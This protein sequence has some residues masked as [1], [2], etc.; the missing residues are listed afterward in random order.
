MLMRNV[1]LE[2]HLSELKIGPETVPRIVAN[3]FTPDRVANNPRKVTVD[4]VNRV[5]QRIR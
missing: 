3:A 4:A 2:T 5:L 1:G